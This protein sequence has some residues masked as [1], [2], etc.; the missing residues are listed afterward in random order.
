MG[1][2]QVRRNSVVELAQVETNPAAP[3]EFRSGKHSQTM[4]ETAG[5]G[6][7]AERARLDGEVV[8]KR[9]QPGLEWYA[10]V[11]S[12]CFA[13]FVESLGALQLVPYA[14]FLVRDLGGGSASGT[15][16]IFSAYSIGAHSG[17]SLAAV[18]VVTGME[19]K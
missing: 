14:P 6:G 12:I 17:P 9:R 16:L 13:V 5:L 18:Q 4:G 8:K 7:G 2:L 1:E 19:P 11:G 10:A 15:G 3:T